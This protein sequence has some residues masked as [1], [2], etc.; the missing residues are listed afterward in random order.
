[1]KIRNQKK[2]AINY[3]VRHLAMVRKKLTNLAKHDP[4]NALGMAKMSGVKI[5]V[6]TTIP[7][8]E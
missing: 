2:S 8:E 7:E 4:K 6:P 5:V 1:M 3:R